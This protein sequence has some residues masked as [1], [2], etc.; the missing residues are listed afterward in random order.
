MNEEQN[1]LFFK[2]CGHL[3]LTAA[4]R[5]L[6]NLSQLRCTTMSLSGI[7]LLMS[8]VIA[9]KTFEF[10]QGDSIKTSWP[11]LSICLIITPKKVSTYS[12][13][14]FVFHPSVSL[15]GRVLVVC[16]SV[17]RHP[18]VQSE[19]GRWKRAR[20]HAR[21]SHKQRKT[22]KENNPSWSLQVKTCLF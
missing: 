2:F 12:L 18:R 20:I 3:I 10:L 16:V 5:L 11:Q 17:Y 8:F 13:F 14:L 21:D 19:G 1:N 22:T 6:W 15:Y 7:Y 9:I 4:S